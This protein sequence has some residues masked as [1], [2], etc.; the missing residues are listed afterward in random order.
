MANDTPQPTPGA[1]E[2]IRGAVMSW[3]IR[4]GLF[5]AIFPNLWEEAEPVLRAYLPDLIGAETSEK[6]FRIFGL[7][8]ALL[9]LKTTQSLWD[10]GARQ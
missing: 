10:K 6:A 3:T 1:A 2:A 8:V 7:A 5:I 9:R 4:L